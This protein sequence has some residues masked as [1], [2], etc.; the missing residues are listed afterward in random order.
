MELC[1]DNLKNIIKNK[2]KYF[3]REKSDP[4]EPIEYFI[5]CQLL[6]E[7]VKCVKYLHD[8]NI[9]HR[10]LKSENFL[11]VKHPSNHRFIKLGDFDTAKFVGLNEKSHTENMG[12]LAIM[13]P[14]VPRG[15]YDKKC[16]IYS[17]GK[18]AIKLF[19]FN[20]IK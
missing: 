5:S 19:D 13:A 10:D 8:Y 15:I 7:V 9:M 17:T 20:V 14:E 18:I 12:T 4:F 3:R 2:R 16:D 11:I 1:S 6:E